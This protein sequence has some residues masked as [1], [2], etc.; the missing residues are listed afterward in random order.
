MDLQ[1]AKH[2]PVLDL[3]MPLTELEVEI[4]KTVV[5]RFFRLKESSPRK[6]LI[7]RFR[8]PEALYRLSNSAILK[9]FNRTDQE[10]VACRCQHRRATARRSQCREDRRRAYNPKQLIFVLR[11]VRA[12]CAVGCKSV[13]G[14]IAS[15]SQSRRTQRPVE[16][17]ECAF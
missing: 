15:R 9:S 16:F 11:D 13:L 8:S 7:R 5:E 4:V 10:Q 14:S 12:W 17:A 1:S 6:L 2:H 3:S